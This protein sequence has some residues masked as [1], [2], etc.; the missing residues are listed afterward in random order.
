MGFFSREEA[1]AVL[2]DQTVAEHTDADRAS[3]APRPVLDADRSGVVTKQE[4]E[5]WYHGQLQSLVRSPLDILY[6]TVHSDKYWWFVHDIWL[7]LA[8]NVIYTWGYHGEF[9]W[10]VP[11]REKEIGGSGAHLNPLGLFLRTSIPFIWRILSVF[12][13][14]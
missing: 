12:L 7:K 2:F 10:N 6:A 9:E 4:F 13:P 11:I 8:V 5:K 14:A 1:E 3:I